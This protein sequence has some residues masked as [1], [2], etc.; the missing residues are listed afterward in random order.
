VNDINND[1]KKFIDIILIPITSRKFR[2]FHIDDILTHPI[3]RNRLLCEVGKCFGGPWIIDYPVRIKF[4]KCE[5][6]G[7][8]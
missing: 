6:V 1:L 7:G 3:N 8:E 4:S 5:F 2:V